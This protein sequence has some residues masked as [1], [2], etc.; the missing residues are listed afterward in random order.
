LR[1]ISMKRISLAVAMAT[2]V[3]TSTAGA[4][5]QTKPGSE[6]R[7]A[8]ISAP[9]IPVKVTDASGKEVQV[10]SLP[11]DSRAQVERVRK[12]ADSLVARPGGTAEAAKIKVTVNCTYPPLVCTITVQ[13]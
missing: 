13:F 6:A 5:A 11:P 3:L 8:S 1:R 4:P 10:E 7:Q 2:F 12:A 9:K